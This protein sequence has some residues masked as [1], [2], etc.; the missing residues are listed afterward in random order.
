MLYWLSQWVPK[1]LCVYNS[2][3]IPSRLGQWSHPDGLLESGRP[4]CASIRQAF[5][6]QSSPRQRACSEPRPP[7]YT[8]ACPALAIS[9]ASVAFL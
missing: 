5:L 8:S 3:R 6:Q 1:E 9:D 7:P 2:S 4:L